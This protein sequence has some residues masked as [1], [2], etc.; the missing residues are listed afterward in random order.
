[1]PR[2]CIERSNRKI[3]PYNKEILFSPY[4]SVNSKQPVF[5]GQA[6]LLRDL[7]SNLL[8]TFLFLI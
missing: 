1:M 2:L 4:C 3:L 6:Y 7:F 5:M 8:I